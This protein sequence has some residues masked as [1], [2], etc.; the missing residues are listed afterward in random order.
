MP[1]PLLVPVTTITSVQPHRNADSL[2]MVQVLGWQCVVQRGKFQEGQQVVYF[3]PDTL[4][5]KELSDSWGITQY[6]DKQRIRATRLRGEPSFGLVMPCPPDVNWSP[7]ENVAEYYGAQKYESPIREF[8]G[9]SLPN[10]HAVPQNPL[11]PE[12]THIVNV[13]NYSDLF[14]PHEFVVITE[15]LHGTNSRIGKVQ[16]EWMAG[17]H[18]VQRGQ[19]DSLYWSPRHH[20][21]RLVEELSTVHQQVILYGEILG[22]DI[23]TLDY[24]YQ[25]H[26][27]YVAFDL[28]IDGRY[29]D[30]DTFETYCWKYSVPVVPMLAR[31]Y[32]CFDTLRDLSKGPTMLDTAGHLREGVVVKPLIER[33]DPRVGRVIAKYVSDDFLLGKHSDFR[34][35]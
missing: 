28:M 26:E 7:G 4:L 5:P 8:R 1:S 22:G 11:F 20:A 21:E 13:R 14:S 25:G 24:G 34:E 32:Y 31:T 19:G 30:Y 17:S 10:P 2:D 3:P 35:I 16:G 15:K 6:L 23:Q 33:T 9:K 29:L 18:R 12:Y 27:G